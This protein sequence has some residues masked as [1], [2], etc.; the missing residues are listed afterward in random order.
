MK[1]YYIQKQFFDKHLD[2]Y[3]QTITDDMYVKNI[4][5]DALENGK[6]IR[7]IIIMEMN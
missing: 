2:A 6:R 7:P 5:G 1:E 4:L 3:I